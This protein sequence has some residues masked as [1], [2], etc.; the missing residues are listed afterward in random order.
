MKR[1]FTMF[2]IIAMLGAMFCTGAMAENPA[3][4][5]STR[6]FIDLL[7]EQ[8]VVFTYNGIDDNGY[9][10]FIVPNT[11]DEAGIEYE[12]RFYFDPNNEN[13]SIRVWDLAKFNASEYND[14][15]V[16][17]NNCH[18]DWMYVTFMADV[19]N[20]ITAKLDLIYRGDSVAE[21]CWEGTL[22][23]VSIITKAYN[24]YLYAVDTL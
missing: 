12:L 24:T 21:V 17:C 22:H 6:Q 2:L 8:G 11:D 23:I 18:L 20:T 16:A 7:N 1:I 13:A 9:E 14:A 5:D 19:D 4:Y 15:I 10:V 3:V